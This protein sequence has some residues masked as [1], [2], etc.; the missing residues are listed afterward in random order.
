ME[1][2]NFFLRGY[3]N[4]TVC[5]IAVLGFHHHYSYTES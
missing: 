1:Y 3:E 4:Y 2:I 5:L